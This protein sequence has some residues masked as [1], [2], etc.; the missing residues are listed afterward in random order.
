MNFFALSALI[1]TFTSLILGTIILFRGRGSIYRTF[2][3][4]AFSVSIWSFSYFV[5]QITSNTSSAIFWVHSL[6]AGAVLIPFLYFHFIVLFLRLQH[7]LRAWVWTGYIFAIFFSII[8]WTSLFV[9]SVGV[10]VDFPSWPLAGPMFLP[11]LIV[12]VFYAAAT[13]L[14]LTQSMKSATKIEQI[15]IKYILVGTI[16]G[17]I[18]GCTNY[19]LWYGIPILPY[20]NITASIYILLV[21]YAVMKH[22]LFKIKVIASEMLVFILWLFVFI[23]MVTASGH[24]QVLDAVLLVVLLVVGILLIRSVDKEVTQRERIEQQSQEVEETNK[25]QRTLIHFIGHQVK[26]FLTKDAAAFASLSEGDFG[27]VSKEAKDFIERALV[28]TRAGARSVMSIL[29]ASDLK[30]G[31]LAYTMKPFDLEVVL[32]E[33]FGRF[34]N[35]ATEKEDCT[36]TFN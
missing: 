16:I 20:G 30:K 10:Q 24:E 19:F 6:M 15:Q 4:F 17:Y 36:C 12:W 23:R 35:V 25:R 1:N 3:L 21:A 18:G 2:A 22:G 13:I 27:D 14:L 31:T 11:F 5:W 33:V 28:E 7:R 8:N 34:T 9:A 29:R 26:G 32:K